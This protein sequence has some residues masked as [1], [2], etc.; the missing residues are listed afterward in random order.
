MRIA[1]SIMR[2]TTRKSF[3]SCYL[4]HLMAE[5]NN[6]S[7]TAAKTK[8]SDGMQE[9]GGEAKNNGN[10]KGKGDG[11]DSAEV[12]NHERDGSP[13][14][15]NPWDDLRDANAV[16]LSQSTTGS[17][18]S[19]RIRTRQQYQH[20]QQ[21]QGDLNG[22]QSGSSSATG[23]GGNVHAGQKRKI[24][25]SGTNDIT[26]TDDDDRGPAPKLHKSDAARS[27]PDFWHP[28]G[29]VII[30]VENTKFRLHQ[31]MLQKNSAYFA[32]MFLKAEIEIDE[33]SPNLPVYRVFETTMGDFTMLLALIEE[34]LCVAAFRR[35]KFTITYLLYPF[36]RR[37]RQY[38]EFT[39]PMHFLAGVL[40]AACALTFKAQRMWA[41]RKLKRMWSETLD[42]LTTDPKPDAVFAL[43]LARACGLRGVE[44]RA[45]YELLRAPTFWQAN[46]TAPAGRGKVYEE[47]DTDS[48]AEAEMGL[49]ELPRADLLRLLHAREQLVLVWGEIARKAPM[50][51]VCPCENGTSNTSN[52]SNGRRPHCMSAN[53]DRVHAHWAELVHATGLYAQRM[54]DPLMGL[55][56][57]KMIPWGEEGFCQRCVAARTNAWE[58][59]RRKLWNNDLNKWLKLT[60]AEIA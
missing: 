48:E 55:Q 59:L 27:H 39:P 42:T 37:T 19:P 14:R 17:P 56:D 2:I 8:R 15:D 11:K 3:F 60:T 9:E 43:S 36:D 10:G 46:D 40:R 54:A 35:V 25:E 26:R 28:D 21:Q 12:G 23:R 13:V 4:R 16:E 31:S 18:V 1:A 58:K 57:L 20:W 52:N 7:T 41:E 49:D 51:F 29:S 34:P 6:P 45:S 5:S 47:S 30:Q 33:Q 50:D 32:A 24:A 38:A 53:T 22:Q 44:K